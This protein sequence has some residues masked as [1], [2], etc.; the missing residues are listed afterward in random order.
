MKIN[1]IKKKLFNKTWKKILI[2]FIIIFFIVLIG[3]LISINYLT[4][5]VNDNHI[6]AEYINV[7]NKIYNDNAYSD[8]YIIID[9]NNNTYSIINHGD[10]Y[11]QK[12]FDKIEVNHMYKVIL[13]DPDVIDTSH[14]VHILEVSNA[15]G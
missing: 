8:Y 15:T 13:K 7:S 5:V 4:D 12:L 3:G 10:G 11:G 9:S 1:D 14:Y 2:V 6:H